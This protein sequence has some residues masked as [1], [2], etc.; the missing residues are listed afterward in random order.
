MLSHDGNHRFG[1]LP[2]KLF[3]DDA[4][5]FFWNFAVEFVEKYFLNRSVIK[6]GGPGFKKI[7]NFTAFV[8]KY[9]SEKMNI[10]TNKLLQQLAV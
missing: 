10:S 5:Y 9:F 2:Q 8:L 7:Y 3:A 1:T 4:V 6:M